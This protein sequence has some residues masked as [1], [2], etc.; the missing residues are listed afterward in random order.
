M[1]WTWTML[2]V[3]SATLFGCLVLLRKAPCVFQTIAISLITAGF[4]VFAAADIADLMGERWHWMVREVAD[5]FVKLGIIVYVWRMYIDHHTNADNLDT[6]PT[7]GREE[8]NNSS[9]RYRRLLG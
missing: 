8:W 2:L 9:R 7:V 5:R 6:P 1:T 4:A 3:D